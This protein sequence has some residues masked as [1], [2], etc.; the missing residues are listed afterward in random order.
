MAETPI[1]DQ[2]K[3]ASPCNPIRKISDYLV[4][5]SPGMRV[6][7]TA[8]A[9]FI[10]LLIEFYRGGALP[11]HTCIATIVCMQPTLKST[12][13]AATDRTIGTVIAGT[14][15]FLMAS[16]LLRV[17]EIKTHTIAFYLLTGLLVF[18]LMAIMIYIKKPASL[19]IGSI[20]FLVIMLTTSDANPLNY[21]LERVFATLL[22][23]AVAVFVNWLP[24]LNKTNN[25]SPETGV[26]NQTPGEKS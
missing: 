5:N 3:K 8:L 1:P 4:K 14:Y 15:A 16:L 26:Q 17:F 24:P 20:V 6:F 10:C 18:P 11:H 21:A 13:K 25:I 19:S 9:V 23:I 2:E 7:K 22:G 12:F